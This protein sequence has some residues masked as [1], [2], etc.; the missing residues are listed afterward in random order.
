MRTSCVYIVLHKLKSVRIYTHIC[1]LPHTRSL[2]TIEKKFI[3]L[4]NLQQHNTVNKEKQQ[5]QNE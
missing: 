5:Q 1:I 4:L 2:Y 3:F